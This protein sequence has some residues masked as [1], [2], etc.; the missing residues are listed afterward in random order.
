MKIG[1]N[2]MILALALSLAAPALAAKSPYN[3][4]SVWMLTFV[5]TEANRTDDYLRQLSGFWKPLMEKAREEGLILS[6][7]MLLGSAANRE[8]FDLLLMVEFKDM[9]TLDAEKDRWEA[10]EDK[11]FNEQQTETAVSGYAQVREILGSK[12][13]RE[14]TLK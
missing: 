4:G 11:L 10:L 5:R 13:M 3:E 8:D 6:Y 7:Q 1:R 9:A 14:I 12:L 2:L